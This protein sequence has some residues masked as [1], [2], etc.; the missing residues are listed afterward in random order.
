M[1]DDQVVDR[2]L[3]KLIEDVQPPVEN[4]FLKGRLSYLRIRESSRM[5]P[6]GPARKMEMTTQPLGEVSDIRLGRAPCI[7][8]GVP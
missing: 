3:D 2:A 4:S 1:W 5:K 6:S 7:N 8:G